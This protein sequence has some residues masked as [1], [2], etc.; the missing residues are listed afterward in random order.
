M[1]AESLHVLSLSDLR[2]LRGL[3]EQRSSDVSTQL[4]TN[5]DD[6]AVGSEA[7]LLTEL[8]SELAAAQWSW[9]EEKQSLLSSVESLKKLLAQLQVCSSVSHT[10]CLVLLCVC[11]CVCAFVN[12]TLCGKSY[13]G[14]G[15][16]GECLHCG[17]N[18]VSPQ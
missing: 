18:I 6:Q 5:A 10:N 14:D 13:V 1:Y 12:S 11:V 8:R 2:Y 3:G 17:E 9:N 15:H 7:Q 16:C 4:S